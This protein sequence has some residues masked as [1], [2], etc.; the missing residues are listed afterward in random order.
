MRL[1]LLQLL[2]LAALQQQTHAFKNINMQ[3]SSNRGEPCRRKTQRHTDRKRRSPITIHLESSCTIRLEATSDEDG[4]SASYESASSLIT[5]NVERRFTAASLE[6][7]EV[8]ISGSVISTEREE[9]TSPA[10]KAAT[11]TINERLLSEIQSSVKDT[12]YGKSKNYF[13]EFRS[14]KTEEE[15]QKSIEE[16]RDLNG[17]NPLVCIGGAAFSWVCAGALWILTR[18]L[19]ALFASH[20][21]DV[22]IYFVQRL[23]QVFRSVVMGLSS[24]ASGFFGVIGVGI[25]LLGARVAYGVMTGELDPTPIKKPKSEETAMPDVWGLM[26]G[27]KPNRRGMRGFNNDNNPFGL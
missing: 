16:A 20:P 26:M 17:V 21:V 1:F 27:K 11:S 3:H 25:F 6:K 7:D 12:K 8:V 15:R 18:Y 19:A 10:Q 23:A 14:T 5:E 24:L 22:D 4:D 9:T 2:C 13:E